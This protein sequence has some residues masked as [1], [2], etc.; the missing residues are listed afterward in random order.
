M[1]ENVYHMWRSFPSKPHWRWAFDVAQDEASEDGYKIAD[2]DPAVADGALMHAFHE[3]M[4]RP[5][6][7]RGLVDG[8]EEQGET[9]GFVYEGESGHFD[10]AVRTFRDLMIGAT[11]RPA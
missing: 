11:G 8:S 1:A 10:S 9:I 2:Y 5:A 4:P 3:H 7:T 6:L